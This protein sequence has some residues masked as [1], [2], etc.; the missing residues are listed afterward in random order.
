MNRL[1]FWICI[2]LFC[3]AGLVQ[4]E[5]SRKAIA[6]TER[7][8]CD[9]V[10]LESQTIL[11]SYWTGETK[12]FLDDALVEVDA[13]GNGQVYAVIDSRLYRIT[14]KENALQGELIE[15]EYGVRGLLYDPKKK[16]VSS[17]LRLKTDPDAKLPDGP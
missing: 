9:L 13:D 1:K 17:T 15:K 14:L 4:A 2:L 12:V 8:S 7:G 3:V 11:S 5:S 16:L 6:F 10:D